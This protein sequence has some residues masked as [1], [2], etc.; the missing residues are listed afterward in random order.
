VKKILIV[1]VMLF[2]FN[3]AQAS[4]AT[5]IAKLFE[6]IGIIKVAPEVTSAA[7]TAAVIET[8]QAAQKATKVTEVEKLTSSKVQPAA[9]DGLSA[10][11][12]T[13]ITEYKKQ[14]LLADHGDQKAMMKLAAM[15]DE[16]VIVDQNLPHFD[17]WIF[18]AAMQGNKV[19]A[20]R[21]KMDCSNIS[22]R[23]ADKGFDDKCIKY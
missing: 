1:L 15:V 22:I 5:A 14:K 12:V 4:I 13:D 6:V 8:E 17:Y 7:K 19:A 11:N 21:L 20:S 2:G 23:K 3:T 18:Q 16:K 9:I 10:A